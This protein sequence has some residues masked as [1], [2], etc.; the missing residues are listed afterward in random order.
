MSI[1]IRALAT[2]RTSARA[3]GITLGQII[4]DALRTLDEDPKQEWKHFVPI[5]WP[6][7]RVLSQMS[8]LY[9]KSEQ[10]FIDRMKNNG[11]YSFPQTIEIALWNYLPKLKR[12]IPNTQKKP[13]HMQV[14]RCT[15]CTYQFTTKGRIKCPRCMGNALTLKKSEKNYYNWKLNKTMEYLQHEY[16][17]AP[18]ISDIEAEVVKRFLIR[19]LKQEKRSKTVDYFKSEIG[20]WLLKVLEGFGN[21]YIK[22]D[23]NIYKKKRGDL[24]KDWF[25]ALEFFLWHA[26]FQGRG[27]ELGQC[28]FESAQYALIAYFGEKRSHQNKQYSIA[29]KNNWIPQNDDGKGFRI[30]NNELWK[31]LKTE[32]AGTKRDMEM[33]LA[34]LYFISE[35]PSKNIILYVLNQI[36][37]GRIEELINDIKSIY[38]IKKDTV[39]PF[40][41]DVAII[42]RKKLTRKEHSAIIPMGDWVRTYLKQIGVSFDED[43]EIMPPAFFKAC[44]KLKIDPKKVNAGALYLGDDL[45]NVIFS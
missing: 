3:K 10:A 20:T 27:N 30:R 31:A 32:E 6:N 34:S 39:L 2:A 12:Q 41:Q 25:Q 38:N 5:N 29:L 13:K 17:E 40:I 18:N 22:E 26:Y 15:K 8:F 4:L 43:S 33:V 16:Y 37:Q 28:Y 1:D 19:K 7:N 14:Y 9:P 45:L 11:N 35:C 21:R 23:L 36:E 44:N 24:R 42:Y